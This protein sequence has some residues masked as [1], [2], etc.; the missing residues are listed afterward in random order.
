MRK[1]AIATLAVICLVLGLLTVWTP[2][3]SGV[4]LIAV[5]IFLL[6]TISPRAK[7]AMRHVRGRYDTVDRAVQWVEARA[8][9]SMATTLKRTRPRRFK[10][11]LGGLAPASVGSNGR[12]PRL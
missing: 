3:P 6:L 10:T 11:K 7:R 9:R 5:G 8:H 4:P 1:I 2:I 12:P